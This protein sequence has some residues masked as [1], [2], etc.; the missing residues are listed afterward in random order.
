[1]NIMREVPA[2]EPEVYGSVCRGVD[3]GVKMREVD[4]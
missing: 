3:P 2:P 1:M 4:T